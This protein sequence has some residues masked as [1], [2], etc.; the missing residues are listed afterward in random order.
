MLGANAVQGGGCSS[1]QK[2]KMIGHM[3]KRTTARETIS[4]IERKM[5]G[6]GGASA[7]AR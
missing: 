3:D 4:T 6:G 5:G 7:I 1:G 2:D